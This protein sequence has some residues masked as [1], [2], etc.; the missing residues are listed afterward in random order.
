MVE[1][2]AAVALA[3]L[4]VAGTAKVVEPQYTSGALQ[5]TGLPSGIWVVRSLGMAE[6]MAGIAGLVLGGPMA[7][8]AAVFYT[9]FC[10]F[11]ANALRRNVP[12]QSC[13]CLGREDTP[14]S[15]LHLTF[16]LTAAAALIAVSLANLA[17]IPTGT[18]LDMAVYVGM[19]GLGTL[20]SALLITRLPAVLRLARSA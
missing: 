17:P 8:P 11:T 6:L 10:V 19:V 7:A 15:T 5:A 14:P 1:A 13:G 9:G 20:A 12:L 3:L 18:P 2:A 4:A 16:N